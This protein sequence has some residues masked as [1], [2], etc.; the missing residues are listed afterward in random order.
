MNGQEMVDALRKMFS[1]DTS[2]FDKCQ[3][4]AKETAK[5]AIGYVMTLTDEEHAAMQTSLEDITAMIATSLLAASLR[6]GEILPTIRMLNESMH[7]RSL[8]EM[9]YMLGFNAARTDTKKE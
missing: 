8:A 7:L 5:W 1:E 4:S 3:S 2:E 6:D 9:S